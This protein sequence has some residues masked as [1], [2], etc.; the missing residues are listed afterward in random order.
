[1]FGPVLAIIAYDSEQEAIAIANDSIYGLSGAVWGSD[2][3][4]VMA[5]ANGLRTG[6]VVVN[7]APFDIMAPIGGYKQS[8]NGRELGVA[9]LREFLEMK[10]L[11]LTPDDAARRLPISCE[12]GSDDD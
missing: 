4:R 11:F 3:D 10:T 7:G 6:R 12:Q 8:G 5:V 9:G 2:F 1:V